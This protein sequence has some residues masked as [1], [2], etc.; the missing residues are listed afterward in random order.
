MNKSIRV[1]GVRVIIFSLII[2]FDLLIWRR[3]DWLYLLADPTLLLVIV[4]TA[5]QGRRSGLLAAGLAAWSTSLLSILPW[6]IH[7]L[8]WVG[9]VGVVWA[10]SRRMLASRSAASFLGLGTLGT[11]AYL[12]FMFGLTWISIGLSSESAHPNWNQWLVVAATH[13]LLHP[14]LAW[15]IWRLSA[16]SHQYASTGVSLEQTF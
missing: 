6:W 1:W 13:L 9:V 11:A 2:L 3:I 5:F 15:L 12:G 8:A 14:P 4:S 7:T 16:R 10:I